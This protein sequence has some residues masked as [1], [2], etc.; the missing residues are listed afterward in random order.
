MRSLASSGA[1][2]TSP[3]RLVVP[4]CTCTT[5]RTGNRDQRRSHHGTAAQRCVA[6]CASCQSIFVGL[7]GDLMTQS[8]VG[9]SQ[10]DV[11]APGPNPVHGLTSRGLGVGGVPS[12]TAFVRSVA[13]D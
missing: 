2:W 12:V 5:G 9:G 1:T 13:G 6:P 7:L 8:I 4:L 10:L 3:L 11:A